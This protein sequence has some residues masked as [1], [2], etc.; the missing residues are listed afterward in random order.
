MYFLRDIRVSKRDEEKRLSDSIMKELKRS[1]WKSDK[2]FLPDTWDEFWFKIFSQSN[3]HGLI[4]YL[5]RK[6]DIL[7]KV[8]A[9]FGCSIY[10]D[11]NTRFLLMHTLGY[12][13]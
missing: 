12:Y 5:I 7:N 11:C 10:R 9:E 4:Q 1:L 3:K 8:F 13:L 2:P 6:V